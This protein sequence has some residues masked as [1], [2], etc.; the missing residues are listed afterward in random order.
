MY[1]YLKVGLF[2]YIIAVIRN[3]KSLYRAK[4]IPILKGIL[5]GIL[6]WPLGIILLLYSEYYK[7]KTKR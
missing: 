2:V 6:L 7:Q 3:Y 4:F 5:F 1:N